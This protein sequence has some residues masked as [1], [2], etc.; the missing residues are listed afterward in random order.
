MFS[1][2]AQGCA[3]SPGQS[4]ALS[5]EV[6]FARFMENALASIPQ[7]TSDAGGLSPQVREMIDDL[8]Q[9]ILKNLQSG[10]TGDWLLVDLFKMMQASKPDDSALDDL[11]KTLQSAHQFD[12]LYQNMVKALEKGGKDEKEIHDLVAS[13]Q[14]QKTGDGTLHEIVMKMMLLQKTREDTARA[15]PLEN[16][17]DLV[18]S[19]LFEPEMLQGL[20]GEPAQGR[21]KSELRDLARTL[22]EGLNSAGKG[23]KIEKV[24][25]SVTNAQDET[26]ITVPLTTESDGVSETALMMKDGEKFFMLND[27]R[28]EINPQRAD[29]DDLFQNALRVVD[30]TSAE[31]AA[32]PKIAP[33]E[34]KTFSNM[35]LRQVIERVFKPPMRFP[36]EMTVR[37][38]PPELGEILVRVALEDKSVRV[39]MTTSNAATKSILEGGLTELRSAIQALGLKSE[40]VMVSLNQ[41]RGGRNPHAFRQKGSK[42]PYAMPDSSDEALDEVGARQSILNTVNYFA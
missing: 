12:G 34:T 35:I 16:A 29:G 32:V 39:N 40:A 17:A 30:S 33:E 9:K 5:G 1:A 11:L 19:K 15:D 25:F 7:A 41:D 31:K 24:S 22:F 27:L 10:K 3:V 28:K 14:S 26:V 36:S 13:M 38:N 2:G 20:L 6:S 18:Q 8:L 21:G 4:D 42:R 23:V 37:I